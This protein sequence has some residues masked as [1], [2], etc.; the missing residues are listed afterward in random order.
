[1][2]WWSKLDWW[3]KVKNLGDN[4]SPAEVDD[5]IREIDGDGD[6]EIDYQGKF[7][8]T[9]IYLGQHVFLKGGNFTSVEN[10]AKVSPLI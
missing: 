5:M 4:L 2:G 1:M 7:V 3:S 9:V 8:W 10:C 6:E